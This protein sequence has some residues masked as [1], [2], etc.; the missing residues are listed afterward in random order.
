M[1]ENC[2]QIPTVK[3]EEN[4]KE[5]FKNIYEMIWSKKGRLIKINFKW[6]IKIVFSI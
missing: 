3:D 1:D 4:H 5:N 2:I 6:I